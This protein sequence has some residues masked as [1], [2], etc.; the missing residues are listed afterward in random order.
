MAT[1]QEEEQYPSASKPRKEAPPAMHGPLEVPVPEW[2]LAAA[3]AAANSTGAA[4]SEETATTTSTVLVAQQQPTSGP[5]SFSQER[6]FFMEQLY[7]GPAAALTTPMSPSASGS[8]GGDTAAATSAFTSF[9]ISRLFL[10]RG[11]V[12]LSALQQARTASS[13]A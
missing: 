9:H 2:K 8:V 12:D 7:G 5:L 4:S 10:L 13:S 6:I 1:L 11:S 3:Q